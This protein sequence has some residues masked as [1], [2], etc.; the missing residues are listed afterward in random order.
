MMVTAAGDDEK[1][2]K[3][4]KGIKYATIALIGIGIS[5]FLMSFIFWL[6]NRIT[7]GANG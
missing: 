2:K 1:Y 5:F 7:L 6:V 3:W 4:L